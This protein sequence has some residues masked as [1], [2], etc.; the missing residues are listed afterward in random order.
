MKLLGIIY[1]EEII[2]NNTLRIYVKFMVGSRCYEKIGEELAKWGMSP[3]VS[4]GVL[5]FHEEPDGMQLL[6]LKEVLWEM[7]YEVI[8]GLNGKRFSE[9]SDLIKELIDRKSVV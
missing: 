3:E 4:Q 1:L 8:D 2:H 6:R 9:V 7:G 5:D